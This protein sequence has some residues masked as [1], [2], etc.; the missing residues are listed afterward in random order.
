L[1]VGGSTVDLEFER[2]KR[3]NDN[4]DLT[5]RDLLR[6]ALEDLDKGDYPRASKCL[7]LIIEADEDPDN[8]TVTHQY[9]SNLSRTEEIAHLDCWK[10]RRIRAWQQD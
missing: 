7:I 9:R 5:P 2:K 10:Q 1:I 4:G 3:T 8:R 6:V